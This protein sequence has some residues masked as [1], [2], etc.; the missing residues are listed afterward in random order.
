MIHKSKALAKA[1]KELSDVLAELLKSLGSGANKECDEAME[2][3]IDSANSVGKTT[4]N[5]YNVNASHEDSIQEGAANGKALGAVIT[6]V[7]S[8]TRFLLKRY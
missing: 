8:G 1:S 3:I 7:L 2:A 5:E 6:M 4:D